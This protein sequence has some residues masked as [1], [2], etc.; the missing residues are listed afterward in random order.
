MKL[1]FSLVL[2]EPLYAELIRGC[3]EA[4]C[5][6]RQFVAEA[7]ESVLASRRLPSVA[8]GTHGPRVGSAES[9]K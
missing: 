6:P 9:T 4:Q 7:L 8:I 2:N 1:E 5:S 3:R